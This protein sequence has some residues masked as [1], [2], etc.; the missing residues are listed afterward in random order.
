MTFWIVVAAVV[1]VGIAFAWWHGGRAKPDTR[2]RSI[3]AEIG[4][5]LGRDEMRN[6]GPGPFGGGGG[7][8]GG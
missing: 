5:R 4:I 6:T 7:I 1:V 2:R 3:N 8:A